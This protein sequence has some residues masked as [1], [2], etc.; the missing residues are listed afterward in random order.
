[1]GYSCGGGGGFGRRFGLGLTGGY[2]RYGCAIEPYLMP[3]GQSGTIPPTVRIEGDVPK[4]VTAGSFGLR[5]G[6]PVGVLDG[7]L[8]STVGAANVAWRGARWVDPS[9]GAVVIGGGMYRSPAFI[10]ELGAGLRTRRGG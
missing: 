1:N 6:M 4:S 5:Y 2:E 10:L 8:V 3:T 7:F 9:T